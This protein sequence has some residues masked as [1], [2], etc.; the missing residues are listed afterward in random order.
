[1]AEII[2]YP[3]R[4][5]SSGISII[6]DDLPASKEQI[7]QICGLLSIDAVKDFVSKSYETAFRISQIMGSKVE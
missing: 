4:K 7:S 5:D 6:I 1:M 3:S 2:V